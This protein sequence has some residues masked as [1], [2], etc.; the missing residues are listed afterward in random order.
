LAVERTAEPCRWSHINAALMLYGDDASEDQA[1]AYLQRWGIL[2]PELTDHVVRFLTQPSSRTYVIAY[3][4][5]LEL[6]QAYAAA[7]PHHFRRLL[8][9]QVRI[10]DLLG[11][12][13]LG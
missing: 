8:T 13:R 1:R 2:P 5:G 12:D 11:E 10:R 4:A 6:C 3:P 9:E 7:A